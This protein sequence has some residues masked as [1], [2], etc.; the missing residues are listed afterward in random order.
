MP[1]LQALPHLTSVRTRGAVTFGSAPA[2]LLEVVEAW[3]FLIVTW[4]VMIQG[5]VL[6]AAHQSDHDSRVIELPTSKSE[7]LRVRREGKGRDDILVVLL[8]AYVLGLL[9]DTHRKGSQ[10]RFYLIAG[11]PHSAEVPGDNGL[12]LV[13]EEVVKDTVRPS[14]D[15][16]TCS[17]ANPNKVG[18]LVRNRTAS[19]LVRAVEVVRLIAGPKHN[20]R[21]KKRL[22]QARSIS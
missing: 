16:I 17:N 9:R 10:V 19:K 3:Q 14:D 1:V 12:N 13:V 7:T 15:E 4:E 5:V 8:P 6:T 18:G 20:T 11:P 2:P 22:F 21:E